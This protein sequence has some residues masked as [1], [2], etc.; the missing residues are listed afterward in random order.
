[1]LN[2]AGLSL[3]Q[4]PPIGIPFAFFMAAPLFALLAALVMVLEG[5]QILAT[6]WSP[7]ALATIHLLALGFLTQIMCG[8][9]FQML[10][11]LAG[12]PV[13]RALLVGRSTQILLTLGTLFLCVGLYWGRHGLLVLGGLTLAVCV[14]LFGW[15][16]GAALRRARGARYTVIAMRFALAG[17]F[18]TLALGLLLIAGLLGADSVRFVR[19]DF[20]HWVNLHL[21]WGLLGWVGVLVMGVAYQVVPMFHV[22]PGY[23]R[24]LMQGAVP[25]V[26]AGLA[27]ASLAMGSGRGAWAGF[28]LALMGVIAFALV[29]LDRQYRRE[30]PRIDATLLY[31]WTAMTSALLAVLLW[32]WGG[33]AEPIGVL[34]FVGVGIALPSGMLFKIMPFLS[35]FHLQYRQLSGRRFDVRIPHMHAFIPECSALIQFGLYL[36]A[37]FLLLLAAAWPERVFSVWL[38]R[39]GGLATVGAIGFLWWLQWRCYAQY[40]SFSRRLA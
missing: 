8:A 26:V 39:L 27:L 19:S 12:S 17:L 3:D 2:T 28:G 35:W 40:R 11:V 5:D 1:M 29:T 10:P 6:R 33:R 23:P 31:W 24:W 18:A 4:A 13:A 25:V 38:V 21:A 37:L 36:V 22:T 32:V 15:A 7:A 30:R 34:A 14:L 16:I 20:A 9:L